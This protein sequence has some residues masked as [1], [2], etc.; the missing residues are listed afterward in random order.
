MKQQKCAYLMT[1][2]GV[3]GTANDNQHTK[4]RL[5]SALNTTITINTFFYNIFI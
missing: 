4:E 1:G 5:Q 3:N 2:T